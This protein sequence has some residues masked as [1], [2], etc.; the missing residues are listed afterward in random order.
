[1]EKACGSRAVGVPATPDALTVALTM[2][3]QA[4]ERGVIEMKGTARPQRLD[5]FHENEVGRA[6]AIARRGGVRQNE[7]FSGFEMRGCLQPDRRHARGGIAPTLRHLANL[8][9]DHVIESAGSDLGETELAPAEEKRQNQDN[10]RET[11]FQNDATQ[12]G[13]EPSCGKPH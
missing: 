13:L 7:K 8:F 6:R 4:F 5:R 10:F 9:E 3:H 11:S 2:N 1:M 12:I